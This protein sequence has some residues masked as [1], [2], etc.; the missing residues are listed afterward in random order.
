MAF[1]SGKPVGNSRSGCGAWALFL[2]GWR[3]WVGGVDR[4]FWSRGGRDG[5]RSF[6]I[7]G[8]SVFRLFH[9]WASRGFDLLCGFRVCLDGES[10]SGVERGA[11]FGGERGGALFPALFPD[12]GRDFDR[13]LVSQGGTVF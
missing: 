10:G 4:G 12:S 8:V 5:A 7:C 9:A 11:E 2:S 3:S 13:L 1:F 6:K